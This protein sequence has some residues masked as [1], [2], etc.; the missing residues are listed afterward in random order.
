MVILKIVIGYNWLFLITNYYSLVGNGQ[1]L[2]LQ[3][4]LLFMFT[5]IHFITLCLKQSKLLVIIKIFQI[6]L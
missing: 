1:V 4:R 2:L 5:C 6:V 3:L